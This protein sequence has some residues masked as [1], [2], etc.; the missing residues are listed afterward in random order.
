MFRALCNVLI[1][2]EI[3]FF[4][5]FCVQACCTGRGIHHEQSLPQVKLQ[6]PLT[7]SDISGIAKSVTT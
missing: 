5:G 6:S 2:A 1:S 7:S 3:C 4:L